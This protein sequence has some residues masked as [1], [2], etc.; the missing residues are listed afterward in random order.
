MLDGLV[1]SPDG[2]VVLRDKME[3]AKEKHAWLGA[4]LAKKIL[5]AGGGELLKGVSHGG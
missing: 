2:K 4:A 3:G 1:A 5:D